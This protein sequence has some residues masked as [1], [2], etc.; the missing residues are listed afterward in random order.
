MRKEECLGH[1]QKRLKKHLLKKSSLCKGLP[2]SKAKRIAHL[3]ALVVV[4]N[5]GKEAVDIRDALNVLLEHSREQHNNYLSG[6][7]SWCS[8]QK[9]VSRCIKD[10]SS[11]APY[12]RSPYFAPNEYQRVKEVF[13]LFA[14]L[15]FCGSIT[16]GKTQNSKESLHSM[17][18]HHAPMRSEICR[19]H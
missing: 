4:Q 9:Q 13:D 6:E 14:S 11:P 5:R 12:I 17:I 10:D 16:L 8:Y 19:S 2:D 7:S 18:W 1:A 3:Y 15:E